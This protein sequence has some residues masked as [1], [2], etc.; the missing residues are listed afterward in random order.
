MQDNLPAKN[1]AVLLKAGANPNAREAY[2]PYF[3]ALI[4]ALHTSSSKN[5]NNI[6]E[7]VRML[8]NAGTDINAKAFDG[9]TALVCAARFS[10]EASVRMLLDKGADIKQGRLSFYTAMYSTPKIMKMLIDAGIDVNGDGGMTPLMLVIM[11]NILIL[12]R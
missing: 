2:S 9:I 1:V 12:K 10:H 11:N 7:V 3:T 8:I 5:E 4:K 6:T